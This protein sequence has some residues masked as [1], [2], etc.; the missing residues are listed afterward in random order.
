MPLW[1]QV[2]SANSDGSAQVYCCG[3]NQTTLHCYTTLLLQPDTA[4]TLSNR[5]GGQIDLISPNKNPAS[6]SATINWTLTYPQ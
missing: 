5:S 6:G 1:L 2:Y 4:E 3:T